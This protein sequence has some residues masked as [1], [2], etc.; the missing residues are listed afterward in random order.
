MG[1]ARDKQA[2]ISTRKEPP[3]KVVAKS[4]PTLFSKCFFDTEN[5]WYF[6]TEV[7]RK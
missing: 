4:Y 3:K 2:K 1:K 7:R 6:Y 5:L